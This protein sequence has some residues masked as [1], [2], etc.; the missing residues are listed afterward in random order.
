MRS[1]ELALIALFTAGIAVLT[2]S[3]TITIFQGYLNFGDVL[4]MGMGLTVGLPYALLGG[5]GAAIADLLL[6]Y[7]QYALPTLIIKGLEAGIVAFY[8]RKRPKAPLWIYLLAGTW[9]A[10][11]YAL[12]DAF[13]ASEL[14]VFISSF[15][16]NIFQGLVAG[17]LAFALQPLLLNLKKRYF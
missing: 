15:T 13:L 2:M 6:G 5:L 4:V 11:G 3:F 8:V 9:M 16:Y 1:K 12:F 14:A 17:A 10:S 7:G